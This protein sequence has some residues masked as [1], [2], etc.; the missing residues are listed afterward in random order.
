MKH[1]DGLALPSVTV[2]HSFGFKDNKLVYDS[3]YETYLNN[4]YSLEELVSGSPRVTNFAGET[5]ADNLTFKPLHTGI[6]GRCYT[7]DYR[8]KVEFKDISTDEKI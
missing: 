5:K 1:D 2:C 3:S 6:K 8:E 4:T 7:L